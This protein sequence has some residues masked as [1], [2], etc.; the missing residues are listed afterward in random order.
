ME[1]SPE[2]TGDRLD[3]ILARK[4]PDISR[5]R[6]KAMIKR[7]LVSLDG[8]VCLLPR[9]KL[10]E[11]QTIAVTIPKPAPIDIKPV[12]MD[13]NIL[14]ED[15]HVVVID[16]PAGLVVHPGA[17]NHDNTLVHGLLHHC[18][19]LSGI[20]GK[21][22]PGIVHRIDKDTS[23]IMIVAKNDAAHQALANIFRRR[24]VKKTYI[25]IT[26]GYL[27]DMEGIV[28]LPIG[29]HTAKRTIMAVDSNRGRQALSQFHVDRD[30]FSAQI[31]RIRIHTGRT[32]QIRVH[33]SYLGH[34]I[35]GDAPYGGK[36]T[37]RTPSGDKVMIPR[38]M[39]H[40]HRLEL[41]HPMEA[42]RCLNLSAPMPEDMKKVINML[43]TG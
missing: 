25:A 40:A 17:G 28:D 9:Q 3:K 38:Q 36:R 14:F 11:H 30:L 5:T 24:K 21:I 41:V 29:R 34:P 16:K 19:N 10:R 2:E 6:L 33:M 15:E 31:V 39:L 22:R 26:S 13:I 1:I 12:P 18:S 42:D 8:E 20:G 35:L 27:P 37:V 32:H 4:I 23:G 43:K 7:G